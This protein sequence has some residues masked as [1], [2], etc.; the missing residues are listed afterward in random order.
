MSGK[1]RYRII[2]RVLWFLY[3][4]LYR[5]IRNHYGIEVY[6]STKI[7]RR[8]VFGHQN[9]IVIHP[10]AEIGDDC[11]IRQNVTIG[12]AKQGP[13]REAPKLGAG[14]RVGCGAVIVGDV[15][16][17]EGAII[18]PNAVVMTDVPAGA[19]VFAENPRIMERPMGL[20]NVKASTE[21]RELR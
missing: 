9:G 21:G 11:L 19:T 13:G 4:A 20:M 5:Y 1:R 15:T 7:G 6:Y 3:I 18:G 12:A 10:F 16:I 8:V 14:V 2:G 17:G